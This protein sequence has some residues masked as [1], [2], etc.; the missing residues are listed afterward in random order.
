MLS[1]VEHEKS[2]I[3]SEPGFIK[4]VGD[5]PKFTDQYIHRFYRCVN[6]A[7]HSLT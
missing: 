2:F 4:F 1:W 3:I 6:S 7:N 5:T